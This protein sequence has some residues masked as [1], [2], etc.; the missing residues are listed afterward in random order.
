MVARSAAERHCGASVFLFHYYYAF[1][2][3]VAD[4]DEVYACRWHAELAL[5][6]GVAAFADEEL[7]HGVEDGDGLAFG[8]TDHD[9]VAVA[10]DH[11][12]VDALCLVNT[13]RSVFEDGVVLDVLDGVL[14]ASGVCA[15]VAPARE[16]VAAARTG[17]EQHCVAVVEGKCGVLDP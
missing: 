12:V 9:E 5:L 3:G 14:E 11:N 13:L 16:A 7:A 8:L 17:E 15:A 2:G 10:V 6:G 1:G 4:F